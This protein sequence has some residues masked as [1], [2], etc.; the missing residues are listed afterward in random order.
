MFPCRV[1]IR[2]FLSLCVLVT[3]TT[4]AVAQDLARYCNSRFGF[5]VE[6]PKG[7]EMEPP[8]AN[9]DGRRFHDS[10]GFWMIA[11]GI[12]NVQDDTLQSEMS[13]DKDEFDTITYE[14]VG[15]N[16]Y[17]LSGMKGSDILYLKTYAGKGSINHLYMEYPAQMKNRYDNAVKAISGS[18]VPGSLN[19][20]H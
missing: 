6:Y 13:S 5:C 4:A 8:P 19:S 11:S 17:V 16:W 1:L 9:N 3:W 10:D 7:L 20:A 2:C 14:K 12:N 15:K 18:F